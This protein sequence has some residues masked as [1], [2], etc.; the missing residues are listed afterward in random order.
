MERSRAANW[1][2]VG[3]IAGICVFDYFAPETLS[4]GVDRALEKHRLATTTAIGVTALHLLNLLPQAVDPIH[5][6]AGFARGDQ[7]DRQTRT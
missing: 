6:L 5:R 7:Y 2:W 3:L 4:E 1:G